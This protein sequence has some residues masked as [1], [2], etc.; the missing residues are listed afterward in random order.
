MD[1]FP[2]YKEALEKAGHN[3][4]LHFNPPTEG[5]RERRRSRNVLWFNPPFCKS[6]KTKLGKE[7]FKII[8]RC[9]P[10]ENPLSK[11]F[12]KN[13]LKLSYSCM[14]SIGKAIS[15]HNK[16][17]LKVEENTPP[18]NCTY[19]ECPV[20]GSCQSSE[21]IYQCEVKDV[22]SGTSKAYI[23]LTGNT[24]KDRYYKHTRSFRVPDYHKNTLSSHIWDLKRRRVNFE[25]SWR[26]LSKARAYSRF[27]KISELC[28]R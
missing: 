23:G 8:R 5:P 6:V 26:I 27:S 13:T 1:A 28:I 2:P 17:I 19:E 21:I 14:P 15:G 10:K 12:N 25:L 3:Y 22:A 11:I 16:K 24:F 7:F 20:S 9:F 4:S 18:C